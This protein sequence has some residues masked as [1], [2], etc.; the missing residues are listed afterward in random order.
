MV[1]IAETDVSQTVESLSECST[2]FMVK[3]VVCAPHAYRGTSH[4]LLC[5]GPSPWCIQTQWEFKSLIARFVSHVMF[6][7]H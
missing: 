5:M 4:M 3:G 7:E 1:S 6:F 2:G